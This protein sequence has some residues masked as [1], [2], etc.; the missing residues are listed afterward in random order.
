MLFDMIFEHE[1][2]ISGSSN[3]QEK[4]LIRYLVKIHA[5]FSSKWKTR[6]KERPWKWKTSKERYKDN[7]PMN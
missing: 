6:N 5:L 2:M 4:Y 3:A 7:E 1:M